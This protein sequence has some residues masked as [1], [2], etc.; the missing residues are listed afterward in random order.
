[1]ASD[2][3]RPASRADLANAVEKFRDEIKRECEK[4]SEEWTLFKR[5]LK[6]ATGI[7]IADTDRMDRFRDGMRYAA[8]RAAASSSANAKS[9]VQRV[10]VTI[11]A[12]GGVILA[13]T[14]LWPLLKNI[15]DMALAGHK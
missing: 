1:M 11:T 2:D 4:R 7:D 9:P 15:M 8:E 10:A 5:E 14:T 6:A 12:A 13:A 3:D